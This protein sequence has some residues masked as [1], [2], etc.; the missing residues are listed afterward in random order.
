MNKKGLSPAELLKSSEEFDPEI[1]KRKIMDKVNKFKKF[2]MWSD[3]QLDEYRKLYNN[4]I[5][6]H[7]IK[8]NNESTKQKG[9]R[10]EDLV[11]FIFE[12][13]FFLSVYPNKRTSINEIDQFVTISDYGIQALH[14]IGISRELLGLC[15]DHFICE[16][17]NYN[18]SIPATWVGKFNTLLNTCGS[19]QLGIIFSYHGLTGKEKEGLN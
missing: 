1:E 16:C 7:K 8:D 5:D 17:K 4:F 2:I 9:D 6:A 19:T 14:D 15:E 13:S 18:K 3:E 11:N 12:N 10:L